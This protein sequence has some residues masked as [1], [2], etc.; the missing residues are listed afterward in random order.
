M[1]SP[2]GPGVPAREGQYLTRASC[3]GRLVVERGC[4]GARDPLALLELTATRE[5]L[6]S[7]PATDSD[8]G[9]R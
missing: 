9:A 2:T 7:S 8:P 3:V 4:L 5:Q 1:R 6:A